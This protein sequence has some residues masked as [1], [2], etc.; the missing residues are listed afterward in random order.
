M[1][2]VISSTFRSA[3]D[4]SNASD[5]PIIFATF[6]HASFAQPIRFN[7]D[8]ADYVYGG[9]TFHGVSLGVQ[10][11]S[12]DDQPPRAQL[13]IMN[14]DR[15]ISDAL[16]ALVDSPTVKLELLS[17]SDF[18]LTVT[19]RTQIGTPTVQYTADNLRMGN[20]SADVLQVTAD[21]TTFLD[22]TSEPW[23]GITGTQKRLPGLYR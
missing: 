23:P 1:P 8:D 13:A 2:R 15:V 16:L 18:N 22:P 11:V 3:I 10:I 4:A 7:S 17:S 20:V 12:D 21:L 5:F 19:P 9:N 14:V 6:T